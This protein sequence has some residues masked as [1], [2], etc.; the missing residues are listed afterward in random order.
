MG[1]GPAVLT[2]DNEQINWIFR[3]LN[4]EKGQTM[5]CLVDDSLMAC[6]AIHRYRAAGTS[7]MLT[8]SYQISCEVS[9]GSTRRGWRLIG[10]KLWI[11]HAYRTRKNSFGQ[12][13]RSH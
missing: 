9:V 3:D 4:I 5:T 13:A 12:Q 11:I 2:D 6:C 1:G 10:S 8:R 7:S